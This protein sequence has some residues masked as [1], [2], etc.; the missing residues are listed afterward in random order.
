[1]NISIFFKSGTR[2][3]K[4]NFFRNS[5][6]TVILTNGSA[7]EVR[8]LGIDKFGFLEVQEKKG[9]IFSVHPDGNSF[10]IF[11]GLIAPRS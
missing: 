7:E 1:M 9:D 2:C 11:K 4:N 8:I 10:D 5:E 6:A 3:S